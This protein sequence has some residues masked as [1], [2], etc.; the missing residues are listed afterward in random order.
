MNFR[1]DLAMENREALPEAEEGIECSELQIGAVKITRIQVVNEEGARRIEKP[2]GDYV[3]IEVPAFTDSVKEFDERLDVM[4]T[5]IEK[6]LPDTGDILVVGL[7]NTGITPD[8]FGPKTA[9]KILATRHI[10]GELAKSVGLKGLRSVCVLSPGVLGQTGI[11]TGEIILSLVQKLKPAA[12]VVVDALASRRLS[13]LGCTVQLCNSG[14]FPGSGVQNRRME[15]SPQTLGVPVLAIGV[16]TIYILQE[17]N[18]HGKSHVGLKNK[19]N[20]NQSVFKLMFQQ[21][22]YYIDFFNTVVISIWYKLI[23]G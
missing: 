22:V 21:P 9:E 10:S 5:E 3:T 6:L 4:V 7:G 2:V 8:A 23:K 17:Q 14:I 12:V 19:C 13:R 16:P 15:I 18:Q 20:D 1:T 11:E